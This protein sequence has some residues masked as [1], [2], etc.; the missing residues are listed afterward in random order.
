[1]PEIFEGC[2]S[3]EEAL[4]KMLYHDKTFTGVVWNKMY[5]RSLFDGISFPKGLIY[6]DSATTYK[7]CFKAER[8]AFTDK[9]LYGYR[10]N[11]SSIMRM[12]YS[13]KML[14]CIPVSQQLFR[15]VSAKYPHLSDAA[16]SLA[17]EVNRV[18]YL[19]LPHSRKEERRK[20]WAELIKYR[21]AV[22]FDKHA[23]K[24]ERIMAL[25][26]YGG[27]EIFYLVSGLFRLYHAKH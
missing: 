24:R 3:R 12:R 1:M 21:K 9:V 23:R 8:I 2:T 25:I 7:L 10:K 26:S 18:V 16:A 11:D 22:L 5:R 17:F 4:Q 27:P 19:N 14:S 15:D 13:P 20:V 6:E